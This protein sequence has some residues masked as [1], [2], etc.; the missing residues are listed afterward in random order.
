VKRGV[1]LAA[2]FLSSC[3]LAPGDAVSFCVDQ[4]RA[5]CDLQFRCCTAAERTSDPAGLFSSFATRRRAPSNA[6]ECTDVVA[7]MCRAAAKQIDE[8][9]AEERVTFDPDEAVECLQTL[10]DAVDACEPADF[11]EA[12]GTFLAQLID[13]AQPGVLG[14][15]CDKALEPQV[16]DGDDCVASYEC[17]EGTCV[18]DGSGD[19]VTIEGECEGDT[20]PVNPLDDDVDFE[21]CDGLEDA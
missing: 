1:A 9:I 6:D 2:L 13:N 12:Q 7:D 16:E 15:G 18:V 10:R 19:D 8:S 20:E 3:T 21:I 5:F 4:A 17:E 14:D 11:F